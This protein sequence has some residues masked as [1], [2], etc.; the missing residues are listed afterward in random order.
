MLNRIFFFFYLLKF[1]FFAFCQRVLLDSFLELCVVWFFC[2]VLFFPGVVCFILQAIWLV[3]ESNSAHCAPPSPHTHTHTFTHFPKLTI[4]FHT[5]N[6]SIL[7]LLHLEHQGE[8]QQLVAVLKTCKLL[9][10]LHHDLKK[11]QIQIMLPL[12]VCL[13][14]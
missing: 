12:C 2:F 8:I 14:V 3:S 6:K 13:R 11:N 10:M 7:L 1:L 9:L 4:Y 5:L